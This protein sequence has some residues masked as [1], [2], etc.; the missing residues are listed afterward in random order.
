M[1]QFVCYD[2]LP[3]C[4]LVDCRN[5]KK[6][7]YE[8]PAINVFEFYDWMVYYPETDEAILAIGNEY[9]KIQLDWILLE[10]IKE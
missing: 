8:K 1:K 4:L 9:N 3:D 2:I 7:K 6:L 5:G 10:Q